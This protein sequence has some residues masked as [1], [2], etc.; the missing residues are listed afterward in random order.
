TVAIGALVVGAVDRV[1]WPVDARRGMLQRAALMM[2]ETAELYREPDPRVVLAP[3]RSSRWRVHRHLEALVQLRCERV[4]LPGTPWFEPE[5]EALR[6]AASTLRL[7]V[8]RIDQARRELD[9]GAPAPGAD[10][11][12]A[13]VAARLD[14]QAAEVEQRYRLLHAT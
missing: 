2:R 7:L 8:A 9:S 1:V 5:E 4:A 13:A 6:L 14:N 11:E 12:R 10:T 3:T